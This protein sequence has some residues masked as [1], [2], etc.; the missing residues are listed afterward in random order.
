M[1]W[2]L[3]GTQVNQKQPPHTPPKLTFQ[4]LTVFLGSRVSWR[5]AAWILTP[6]LPLTSCV[7]LS[8]LLELNFLFCEME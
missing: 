8:K 5:Q 1:L 7:T 2:T 6:I 3:S 4:L